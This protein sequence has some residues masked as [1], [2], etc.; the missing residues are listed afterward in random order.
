M[1]FSSRKEAVKMCLMSGEFLWWHSW[2][3]KSVI[4]FLD[5]VNVLSAHILCYIILHYKKLT[6]LST[7]IPA[8]SVRTQQQI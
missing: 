7:I 6:E 2:K 1:T 5:T 8:L 3:H 4:F